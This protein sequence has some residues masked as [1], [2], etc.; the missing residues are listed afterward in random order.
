MLP[1][2]PTIACL[3]AGNIGRSFALT[4]A[5]AGL[6]VR[7]YDIDAAALERALAWLAA[8]APDA[9]V[10]VTTD[11]ANA[12][13]GAD[14]IQ[15]NAPERLEIKRALIDEV[16]PLMGEAAILGSSTTQFPGS[17]FLSGP[18]MAVA[19]PVNPPHLIPYV[20]LCPTPETAPAVLDA[21][22]ALMARIGQVPVRLNGEV[23]GF[24]LNRL[25]YALTAE[26]LSLVE[27]GIASPEAVDAAIRDGLGRRWAFLGVFE[28][29]HLNAEGGFSQYMER[30]G[31]GIARVIEDLAPLARPSHATVQAIHD[32]CAARH[33]DVPAAQAARDAE[34]KRRLG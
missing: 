7:L 8:E 1:D 26:A 16:A 10:T 17:E 32:A 28:T 18:R 20:E 25:Q 33:A 30:L 5:R 13:T 9:A 29:Q 23:A 31:E 24:I 12:I 21:I 14:Y 6:P 15:E 3:G 22:A 27:R 11:L 34:I 4:F 2:N 19:H